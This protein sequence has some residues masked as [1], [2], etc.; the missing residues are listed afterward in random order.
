VGIRLDLPTGQIFAA[1]K[2]RVRASQ[3]DRAFAPFRLATRRVQLSSVLSENLLMQGHPA[4]T[5]PKTRQSLWD[6]RGAIGETTPRSPSKLVPQSA[7]KSDRPILRII[8][9]ELAHLARCT[10]PPSTVQQPFHRLPSLKR[11]EIYGC[12]PPRT[13]P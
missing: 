3:E 10:P 12:R 7:R 5:A 13:N 4:T 8:V 11:D 1:G 6:K 9:S 2:Q